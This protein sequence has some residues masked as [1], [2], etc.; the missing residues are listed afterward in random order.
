[1]TEVTVLLTLGAAVRLEPAEMVVMQRRGART[2][3][4]FERRRTLTSSAISGPHRPS[5]HQTP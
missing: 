5:R 3:D 4:G 1:M 2:P